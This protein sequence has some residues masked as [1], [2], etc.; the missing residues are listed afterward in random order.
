VQGNGD[1]DLCIDGSYA[2]ATMIFT[3]IDDSAVKATS[4]LHDRHRVK[5]QDDS[6]VTTTQVVD[7]PTR[8]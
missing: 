4:N 2:E 7:V 8:R 5:V 1:H 3:S 6:V